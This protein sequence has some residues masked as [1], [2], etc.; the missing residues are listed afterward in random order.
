MPFDEVP[1]FL[2][3]GLSEAPI[4]DNWAGWRILKRDNSVFIESLQRKLGKRFPPSFLY[5]VSNY[6]FPAFE[7]GPLMFFANKGED[8]FWELGKRLLPIRTCRLLLERGFIQIGE[9]FCYNTTPDV[10]FRGRPSPSERA[11]AFPAAPTP[12]SDAVPAILRTWSA[13]V[14]Q[15]TNTA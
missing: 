6:S 9:R 4:P 8:D 5:F 1:E 7:F 3:E 14:F 15:A 2:R 13:A 11:T 10:T 12:E